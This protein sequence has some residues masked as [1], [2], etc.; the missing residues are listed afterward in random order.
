MKRIIKVLMLVAMGGALFQ[1]ATGCQN[2]IAPLITNVLTSF[3]L[4]SLLGGGSLI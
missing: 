3:I 4:Q 2:T 1:T